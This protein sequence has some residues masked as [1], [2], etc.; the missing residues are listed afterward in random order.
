MNSL[1]S[2]RK[3][4]LRVLPILKAWGNRRHQSVC[5]GGA[6]QLEY[7]TP[8]LRI[9]EFQAFTTKCPWSSLPFEIR[10][11]LLHVVYSPVYYFSD[12]MIFQFLRSGKQF[13]SSSLC[14]GLAPLARIFSLELLPCWPWPSSPCILS[15]HPLSFSSSVNAYTVT[16][17]RTPSERGDWSLEEGARLFP[18]W[19]LHLIYRTQFGTHRSNKKFSY[20][21]WQTTRNRCDGI[22]CSHFPSI[23]SF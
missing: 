6:G 23:F 2:P 19:H 22:F 10:A 12:Q 3:P 7:A 4:C 5:S 16:R 8:P 1:P 20:C 21:I 11:Q 18:S 14:A 13:L 9:F 15:F 17:A